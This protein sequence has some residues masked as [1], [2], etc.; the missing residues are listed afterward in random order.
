MRQVGLC[1]Q[2]VPTGKW[3][4]TWVP[5]SPSIL[6]VII[7]KQYIDTIQLR[8][9]ICDL[10]QKFCQVHITTPS[11][12]GHRS[13]WQDEAPALSPPP[14]SF[15]L[16]LMVPQTWQLFCNCRETARWQQV[17]RPRLCSVMVAEKVPGTARPLAV[18]HNHSH[19][20]SSPG[21]FQG[22]NLSDYVSSS[23]YL[24]WLKNRVG[25]WVTFSSL[26]QNTRDEQ[27]RGRK[28]GSWF[29]SVLMWLCCFWACAGVEHNGWEHVVIESDFLHGG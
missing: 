23:V 19:S 20:H 16:S 27:P 28:A 1:F 8:G 18:L 29:Q 15:S 22:N 11:F 17:P 26:W 9:P 10:F 5:I 21:N 6:K 14:C 4:K 13:I 3:K 25:D 24:C 7:I 12:P 2:I